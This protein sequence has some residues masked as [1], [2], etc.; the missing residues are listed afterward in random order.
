MPY[1]LRFEQERIERNEAERMAVIEGERETELIMEAETD[2]ARRRLAVLQ[3]IEQAERRL[4]EQKDQRPKTAE[5]ETTAPS[6]PNG[7]DGRR[8]KQVPLSGT[9]QMENQ[10]EKGEN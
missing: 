3:K 6:R 7:K 1:R 4:Y 5:S 10:G 2:L 9:L 8:G